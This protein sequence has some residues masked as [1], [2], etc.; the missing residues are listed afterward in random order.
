MVQI[1]VAADTVEG[2]LELWRHSIGHGGINP[3]P[4]P[5]RVV[6]G[7]AKLHPRLIRIFIQEFFR[8]YPEHGRFDWSRLDPYM[9]ALA[10]TGAKI[11]AAI[12]IKPKPLYPEINQAVWRPND[13]AE[14]QHVIYELVRRYSVD[15]PF[16]TYWEVGNEFDCGEGGGCPYLITDPHDYAEYY[17]M[18]LQPILAAFPQARVG[19]PAQGV[20][21]QEPLPGFVKLCARRG[22]Q[23]DLLTWHLYHSDPS[24][25][26][27]Q[28]R[29]AHL[30]AQEL[31][32]Q[33]ELMV[34]E[35]SSGFPVAS[36][37]DEALETRR[38]AGVAA[39]ILEMRHAGLHGS[40]YYH[41]W[42]QVCYPDDFAPFFSQPG[43]DA[44]VHHWNEHPHRFGL[45]GVNGEVRP[46]YFVFQMLSRLG[47]DQLAASSD[48]HD[49]R[50]LAGRAPGSVSVLA[51]NHSLDVPRDR[52]VTLSFTNLPP[53]AKRLTLCR[54]DKERRWDADRLELVPVEQRETCTLCEYQCQ[55]LLPADSVAL[56]QLSKTV[57]DDD[58]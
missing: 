17:E 7:A 2:P 31:P 51:V 29:I 9:E 27:Y 50:V 23:L 56:L 39:S 25:H 52:L 4:L 41:L 15:R 54:I 11:V 40:F 35:W 16:V 57:D 49:V 30:L 24:L 12:T 8:I 45:F 18:A 47:E 13:I 58:R 3:L 10:R 14:W 36:V 43:V 48:D 6:Q 32:K 37:Q 55:F 53:G 20:L 1:R 22:T 33:P 26:G 42:D 19:G 38:A 28:T 5:D 21:H 44:M 34:T 46:Q